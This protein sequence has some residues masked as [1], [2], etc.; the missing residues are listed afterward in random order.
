MPTTIAQIGGFELWDILQLAQTSRMSVKLSVE[1][2][3][4]SGAMFFEGGNL[5]HAI[6]GDNVGDEAVDKML[7]WREGSVSSSQLPNETPQTVTKSSIT[8]L[9]MDRARVRDEE[10]RQN[11]RAAAQPEPEVLPDEPIPELNIDIETVRGLLHEVDE[12]LGGALIGSAVISKATGMSIAGINSPTRSSA[13]FNHLSEQLHNALARAEDAPAK[14]VRQFVIEGDNGIF[15]FVIEIDDRHRWAM[16][17]DGARTQLGLV[18][19][20]IIPDILPRLT[21][22]LGG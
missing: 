7:E 2:P 11:P 14:G 3:H 10:E 20:F 12:Q 8:A 9:L 6:A 17:L 1:S 4:G 19:S 5:R 22:A 16:T 18:F 15:I 13:L 21:S